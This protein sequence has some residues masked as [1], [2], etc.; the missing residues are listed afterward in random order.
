MICEFE[1]NGAVS[2]I[3]FCG[4]FVKHVMLYKILKD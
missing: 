2:P 4:E 1:L 3:I